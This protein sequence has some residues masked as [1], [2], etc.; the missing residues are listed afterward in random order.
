MFP[1]FA[2]MVPNS[3]SSA[4]FNS[5]GLSFAPLDAIRGYY[6]RPQSARRFT[7]DEIARKENCVNRQTRLFAIVDHP[8][9]SIVEYPESGHIT[10]SCIGHR[11]SV[12]S[13][14]RFSHP[15]LNIQYSLGDGHGSRSN[16]TCGQLLVDAGTGM[17]VLC[18]NEKISCEYPFIY[19]LL[20]SN[21][22]NV[23]F[24]VVA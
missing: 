18:K 22:L 16:V 23:P 12:G 6:Y 8:V 2:N 14:D 17:P 13:T 19:L 5:H 3:L 11:F 24:Q 1:S 4:F 20:R 7:Q 21:Y 10:G 15:K 9:G